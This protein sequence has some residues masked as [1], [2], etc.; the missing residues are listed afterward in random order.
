MGKYGI[1]LRVETITQNTTLTDII[2]S[3]WLATNIGTAPVTI[4]GIELQ[5]TERLSSRD[6][7]QLNTG[8]LWQEPIPIIVQT[9]GAVRLLRP[10][11]KPLGEEKGGEA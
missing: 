1:K 7:V 3:G 6:I 8:D 5:P 2:Y 11:C 9:G 4:Y 10:V